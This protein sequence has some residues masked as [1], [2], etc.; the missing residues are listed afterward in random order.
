MTRDADGWLVITA[1]IDP[2]FYMVYGH[3]ASEDSCFWAIDSG[4]SCAV[5]PPDENIQFDG[6]LRQTFRLR[7][8]RLR[9]GEVTAARRR[10][11]A[12]AFPG[13]RLP[14]QGHSDR[15]GERLSA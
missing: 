12:R 2:T 14:G 6:L 7:T 1:V 9:A 5:M 4:C 8:A 11:V 3:A 13:H 10:Q 15:S